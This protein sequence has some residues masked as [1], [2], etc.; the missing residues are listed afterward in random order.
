MFV[1]VSYSSPHRANILCS[2]NSIQALVLLV[3]EYISFLPLPERA[4]DPDVC[5]ED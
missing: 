5:V 4:R 2:Y 1:C 3:I